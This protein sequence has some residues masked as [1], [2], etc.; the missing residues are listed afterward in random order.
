M[1]ICFYNN[2][3]FY[4]LRYLQEIIS[5]QP[6][7]FHE[8]NIDSTLPILKAISLGSRKKTQITPVILT[9]KM[10]WKAVLTRYWRTKKQKESGIMA[11]APTGHGY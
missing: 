5:N 1:G 4:F 11:M 6:W 2:K 7:M 9:E 8:D 3:V 10:Q